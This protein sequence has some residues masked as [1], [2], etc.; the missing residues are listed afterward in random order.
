MELKIRAIRVGNVWVGE[1]E[2]YPEV[3]ERALTEESAKAKAQQIARM[4][5]RGEYNP[6]ERRPRPNTVSRRRR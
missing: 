6:P 4:I 2:G 3:A 5:E 1:I